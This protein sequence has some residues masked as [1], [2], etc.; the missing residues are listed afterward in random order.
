VLEGSISDWA[1]L[2]SGTDSSIM[3]AREEAEGNSGAPGSLFV[4]RAEVYSEGKR[5]IGYILPYLEPNSPEYLL[6]AV[7]RLD[8]AVSK[9]EVLRAVFSHEVAHS[10]G[11][12]DCPA[13][14][15]GTSIMALFR[16]RNKGNG[17]IAP[18]PC[19]ASLIRNLYK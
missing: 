16:G 4:M 13:C 1:A 8:M 3:L 7:V 5:H 17:L 15:R 19:D 12:G 6:S 11:L 2:I 10:F 18:S 9:L 14:K